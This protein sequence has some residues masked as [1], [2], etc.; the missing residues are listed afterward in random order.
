MDGNLTEVYL[1][2]EMW[3]HIFSYIP[4]EIHQIRLVNHT[5]MNIIDK[6][7]INRNIAILYMM[8]ETH[9]IIQPNTNYIFEWCPINNL[10]K[11]KYD[12]PTC[13]YDTKQNTYI[14][15][16]FKQANIRDLTKAQIDQ[17]QFQYD[18]DIFRN[19]PELCAYMGYPVLLKC[20]LNETTNFYQT[21]HNTII[22]N[23]INCLQLVIEYM[24]SI[25]KHFTTSEILQLIYEA[26]QYQCNDCIKLLTC[27]ALENNNDVSNKN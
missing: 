12:Y 16:Q 11:I 26:C 24:I 4:M 2:T 23:R 21:I 19:M 5:F 22:K 13:E 17:I 8:N 25:S 7:L 15:Y 18:L 6:L 14:G 10:V 20:F 27:H 9:L 3:H 1:P